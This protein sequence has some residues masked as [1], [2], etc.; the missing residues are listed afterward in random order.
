MARK[1]VRAAKP[2]M[3]MA[4]G[5]LVTLTVMWGPHGLIDHAYDAGYSVG[6]SARAL[7]S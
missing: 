7:V 1:K 3:W 5:S 6:S 2:L 4:L